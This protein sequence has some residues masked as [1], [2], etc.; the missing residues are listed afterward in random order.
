MLDPESPFYI[1]PRLDPQMWRWLW[2]FA[3]ACTQRKVRRA[4]PILLELGRASV[5]LFEELVSREKL[6]FGFEQK[7]WL[8]LFNSQE[9][10]ESGVAEAREVGEF[11]VHFEIL[12]VSGVKDKVP[13][14]SPA[15]IGGVYYPEDA[16]LIPDLFVKALAEQVERE[17]GTLKTST[18]VLGFDTSSGRL[19]TVITT[20]GDFRAD[21]V[22]LAAGAWSP[23][24]MRELGLKLPI[25]A[26]KGY[27]ITLRA[28][29]SGPKLPLML[30]EKRIAVTPM[31]RSLRFAGT[32]EMA[33]L[34][35]SVDCRRVEAIRGASAEY[36]PAAAE[37]ELIEIWRGL[38]PTSPD[39]LPLIGRSGRFRNLV[40][41]GGHGTLGISLAPVT[42]ELVVQLLT[43]SPPTFNLAPLSPDR[44]L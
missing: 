21:Q 13:L 44:F 30:M 41:A 8:T 39:G 34:D 31:G 11:G 37:A 12:D 16:H 22:V 4:I 3:R 42:G 23:A 25:Q 36:L 35:L 28:H 18:E 2:L 5:Q 38:R 20:R 7:G 33:G 17:G 9:G 1:K 14:V 24:L 19:S 29:D 6:N 43:D 15:V 40:V 27:S 10:L 26:A 32:L